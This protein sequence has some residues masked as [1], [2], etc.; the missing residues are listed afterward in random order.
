MNRILAVLLV[1]VM[2]MGLT[3][4]GTE[5]ETTLTGMVTSIDGTVI[6]LMEMDGSMGGKDFEGG[7]RPS[8]PEGIEGFQGFG[9]FNPED[10]EGTFPEG[11]NFPQWGEGEIPEFPESEMPQRPENG[12]RPEM[13]TGENGE[14]PE[15]PT[16][17]DGEMQW[18]GIGEDGSRRPGSGSFDFEGET[19]E[20][21]IGNAH[22]SIEIDGGKASGTLEDITP[23]SFVTVTRNSKG[24][25]TNVLVS[26]QSRFGGMG[27]FGG[28]GNRPT[29]DP[30]T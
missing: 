23:G 9:D 1:M 20:I 17:E 24:E 29:E 2:V 15:I 5:K 7:E 8:R 4:C 21:D 3:A 10:F 19:T 14:R 6:S 13:P 11:E 28:R 30:E 26:S 16:G 25:V 12:E 22:I 27:G 18:Q